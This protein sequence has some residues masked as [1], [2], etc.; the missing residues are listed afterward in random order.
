MGET[1]AGGNDITLLLFRLL[2]LSSLNFVIFL[3]FILTLIVLFIQTEAPDGTAALAL[4]LER[5]LLNASS[6]FRETLFR[7]STSD[8][9]PQT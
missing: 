3:V 5:L 1:G 7:R 8:W 9:I 4:W 6:A 2:F